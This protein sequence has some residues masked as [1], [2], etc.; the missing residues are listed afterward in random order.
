MEETQ[1]L[2]L[3]EGLSLARE[4]C[5]A[6][7]ASL[8]M[9]ISLA[10]ATVSAEACGQSTVGF[11]HLLDYLASLVEG[12]IDGTAEPVISF[13]ASALVQV[14]AHGGI[15]QLGF[16]RAFG[17]L[18]RRT[19]DHGIAAFAQRNSY[20]TGEL[21]YYVRRLAEAGL[22]AVTMSNGPPLMAPPGVKRA[23]YCTNPLAFA[24]PTEAGPSVL[25][26]QASSATA[27]VN[28]REAAERGA[29]LPEGWAVDADGQPT[30]DPVRALRGTLL[31]FG[32]SRGANIALM[33]EIMAAGLTG[34][35]WSIDAPAFQAGNRSP[36]A[37]LLVMVV[38]PRLLDPEFGERLQQHMERLAA[39]GVYIP[40]RSKADRET[41]AASRGFSLPVRLVRQI[42]AF[43]LEREQ[44]QAR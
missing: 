7:G 42:E 15:A 25:L 30:V 14:D 6:A 10:E 26:D 2:T 33:I 21:G 3:Q 41:L 37:G 23:V 34:A 11:R 40:G 44:G 12:R 19:L 31:T 32:G 22:L 38:A 16:D 1:R 36:G 9:A 35:N 20:S 28:V 43:G 24:A 8:S 27:F 5:L 4:A 29:L 39:H 13:P 18:C 17:E